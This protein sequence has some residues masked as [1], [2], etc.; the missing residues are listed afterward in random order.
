MRDP[1]DWWPTF[2]KFT[3]ARCR[4]ERIRWSISTWRL[5]GRAGVEHRLLRRWEGGKVDTVPENFRTATYHALRDL[6]LQQSRRMVL[7][8][9]KVEG[10]PAPPPAVG[11]RDPD[12]ISDDI[13]SFLR[14]Q[15]A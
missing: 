7:I 6:V 15:A 8:L 10:L 11:L 5:A 14:R 4:R 13:P 3:A 9:E 2:D 1:R 12:A